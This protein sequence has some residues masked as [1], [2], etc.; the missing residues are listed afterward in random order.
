MAAIGKLF[1][2]SSG[3][4]WY[5]FLLLF[6]C[7]CNCNIKATLLKRCSRSCE[8]ET[9]RNAKIQM[10]N[11]KINSNAQDPMPNCLNH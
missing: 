9:L 6:T 11:V 4:N 5:I 8:R 7:E 1:L 10:P 3:V 2:M